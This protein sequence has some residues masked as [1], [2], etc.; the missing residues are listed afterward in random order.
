MSKRKNILDS[1]FNRE[2]YKS[3]NDHDNPAEIAKVFVENMYL[4]GYNFDYSLN[5][6][7]FVV[8]K[9]IRKYNY[10]RAQNDILNRIF[11]KRFHQRHSIETY[12]TAYIGETLIRIYGGEWKGKFYG[13]ENPFGSNF[14]TSYV[15]INDYV[16]DP[17]HFISGYLVNGEKEEGTFY[18]YL[19]SR[20]SFENKFGGYNGGNL[21]KK[22]KNKNF[23]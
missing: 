18:E 8:D 5:S 14:Y 22:I 3:G 21:I 12:L 6:L 2:K 13:P 11:K 17:N 15:E 19:Y 23:R 7:E 10:S 4:K 20:N 16:F 1:S 9:L